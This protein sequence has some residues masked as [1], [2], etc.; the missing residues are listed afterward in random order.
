ML[1][2]R[3]SSCE[4]IRKH[5]LYLD[6]ED[7]QAASPHTRRP[8]LS[9]CHLMLLLYASPH[10]HVGSS[11][12]VHRQRSAKLLPAMI[13]SASFLTSPPSALVFPIPFSFELDPSPLPYESLPQTQRAFRSSRQRTASPPRTTTSTHR[14]RPLKKTVARSSLLA[15]NGP[16]TR[17]RPCAG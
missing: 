12:L 13:H 8:S 5:G 7:G 15:V 4:P 9:S 3:V 1:S 2:A 16:A 17:S 14:S 11:S 6:V 10:A